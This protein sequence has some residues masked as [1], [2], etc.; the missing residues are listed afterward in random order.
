MKTKFLI[1]SGI[2]TLSVI[3]S[4]VF[5]TAGVNF[6]DMSYEGIKIERFS[7]SEFQKYVD[8]HV[9]DLNIIK[10]TDDDL[11]QVPKI[12][13]L[14]NQSLQIE[15]LLVQNDGIETENSIEVFAGLTV[16]EIEP[17]QKW[18]EDLGISNGRANKSGSILEYKDQYYQMGF[19]IA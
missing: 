9:D 3:V 10:I 11:R 19:T 15:F 16:H 12:K 8:E 18:G 5:L 1:I 4:V 2:A 13:D 17:Y 7:D 6:G 14:I